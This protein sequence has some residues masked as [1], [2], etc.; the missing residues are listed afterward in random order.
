MIGFFRALDRNLYRLIMLTGNTDGLSERID[1]GSSVK[2]QMRVL[3][4]GG[5]YEMVI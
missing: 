2:L 5:V 3:L 1:A 4:K